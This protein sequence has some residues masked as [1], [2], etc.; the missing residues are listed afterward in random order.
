MKPLS[1]HLII[2]NSILMTLLKNYALCITCH[3]WLN[4]H[5]SSQTK[6]SLFCYAVVF[7]SNYYM[8]LLKKN[9][10]QNSTTRTI[11]THQELS[12]IP[13]VTLLGQFIAQFRIWKSSRLSLL[14]TDYSSMDA[15]CCCCC[16][17]CCLCGSCLIIWL[18]GYLFT[19]PCPVVLPSHLSSSH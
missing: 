3:R 11:I 16:C 14:Y 13:M 7:C 1:T 2:S 9:V 12:C 8:K 4:S 6:G 19:V 10:M 17:C 15:C 5:F 18:L